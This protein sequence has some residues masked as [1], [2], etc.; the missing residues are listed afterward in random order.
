MRP[1]PRSAHPRARAVLPV[2]SRAPRVLP[3]SQSWPRVPRTSS[4][5][6][7]PP[8]PSTPQIWE[9][10]CAALGCPGCS[11]P[12]TPPLGSSKVPYGTPEIRTTIVW[13]YGTAAP[14][15][16]CRSMTPAWTLS[17]PVWRGWRVWTRSSML[18]AGNLDR[19]QDRRGS[20]WLFT[21]GEEN[22]PMAAQMH[23][24][25]LSIPAGSSVRHALEVAELADGSRITLPLLLINGAF[26]GPRLYLGAAIHGDEVSGVAIRFRTCAQVPPDTLAGSI[27]CVLVQNP[28]AFQAEHRV[29][30]GLY[31]KSP[32]E[33]MPIDP[34][35]SFPGH[36]EGNL[37]ER[38]AATLFS[39]MTTCD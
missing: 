2:L 38:L 14:P 17:F 25:G 23:V 16:P 19:A 37:T 13:W 15:P 32:L 29:P 26:P 30:V 9:S 6:N 34:W 3:S 1:G 8:A 36:A 5:P 27:V 20:V 4:S 35:T 18:S 7:T 39:L 22:M 12:D 31:L 10:T 33:Q 24:A 28:L 11:S 21:E